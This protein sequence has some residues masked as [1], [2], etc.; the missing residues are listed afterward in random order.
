M[1][2][3]RASIVFHSATGDLLMQTKTATSIVTLV[4]CFTVVVS[5]FANGIQNP[6]AA[7]KELHYGWGIYQ[8]FDAT[9][10]VLIWSVT[11]SSSDL[12]VLTGLKNWTEKPAVAVRIGWYLT[13]VEDYKN[14]IVSGQTELIEFATLA[15]GQEINKLK[16]HIVSHENVVKSLKGKIP[17]GDLFLGVQVN[18]VH[19]ADGSIW[20]LK[21]PSPAPDPAESNNLN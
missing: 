1:F 7:D 13:R 12:I 6:T 15:G 2:V 14:V 5:C 8:T 11:G 18:E 21:I 10:N 3:G 9:P 20:K 19:F 16:I 17:E 4:C